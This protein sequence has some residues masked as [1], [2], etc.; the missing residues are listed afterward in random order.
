MKMKKKPF[1]IFLGIIVK[2]SMLI[3][4][5]LLVFLIG[6]ILVKGVPHLKPSLFSLTYTSENVSIV[7]AF[8]TTLIMTILSLLIAVPLGVFTA[9]YLVEYAKRG[10]KLVGI[11]RVTAETLSGIPSIVYGLFGLLFFVTYLKWGYSLLAGAFTLS[12]MVLPLIMRTTEEALLAVPD[13]FREGSFG[14]GAGRLRTVF[15]IVLPSAI[16]GILAGVILAIGRIVGE[17]AA[18]I[19][20]A[21]TVAG[22]PKNA[23]SSA[24][25]LAV[26]MYALSSEG[27]YTNE[28]YATAVVLLVLVIGIN[29]LAGFIAKK[30]TRG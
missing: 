29:A 6:Y 20:T 30:L 26:H 1:D 15:K 13:G 10:N 19:Y 14:L 8:V 24:R 11:I 16:P 22:I 25:T 7:P 23:L 27:L 18:L 28:A 4:V 5:S 9:I 17:T 2:G 3:T 12:I 21:G